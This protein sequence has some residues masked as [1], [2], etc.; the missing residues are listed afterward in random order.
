MLDFINAQIYKLK[1][2]IAIL[3]ENFTK[4]FKDIKAN[5]NRFIFKDYAEFFRRN[6]HLKF[7]KVQKDF[8]INQ[9]RS[10]K[11]SI[12]ELSRIILYFAMKAI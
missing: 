10:S 4:E 9:I 5:Q 1:I 11:L 6:M 2:I 12:S 3:N 8:L 7:T